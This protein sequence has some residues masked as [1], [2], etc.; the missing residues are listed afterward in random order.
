MYLT[1]ARSKTC[2]TEHGWFARA[3]FSAHPGCSSLREHVALTQGS[4][5]L[6]S[7][8]TFLSQMAGWGDVLTGSKNNGLNQPKAESRVPCIAPVSRVPCIAPVSRVPCIARHKNRKE[9]RALQA[10]SCDNLN[11]GNCKLGQ[12]KGDCSGRQRVNSY[13]PPDTR[14]TAHETLNPRWH[15]GL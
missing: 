12:V 15:R 1:S 5:W 10:N 3:W 13:A 4:D 8:P 11:K 14:Y 9:S 2:S 7:K 6:L